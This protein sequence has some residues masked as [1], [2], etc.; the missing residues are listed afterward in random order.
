MK[1]YKLSILAVHSLG[2]VGFVLMSPVLPDVQAEYPNAGSVAVQ[3]LVTLPAIC[4]LVVGQISGWMSNFAEKRHLILIGLILFGAGGLGG[5]MI[6]S[7]VLV[8]Q[9]GTTRLVNIKNQDTMTKI[10]DMVPDVIDRFKS[11]SEDKMTEED[12]ADLLNEADSPENQE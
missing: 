10:L 12:V 6:P 4:S 8:I 3:M 9:N 5:K 11:P 2:I 1:K 7:A